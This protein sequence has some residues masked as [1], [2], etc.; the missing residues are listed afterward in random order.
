MINVDSV[1]RVLVEAVSISPKRRKETALQ[2]WA[3]VEYKNNVNYALSQLK[4]GHMPEH[5]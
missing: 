3:R 1:G 5:I 4:S 2:T